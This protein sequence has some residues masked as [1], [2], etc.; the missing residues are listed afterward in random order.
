M[1]RCYPASLAARCNSLYRQTGDHYSIVYD[2]HRYIIVPTHEVE[3]YGF[4]PE[5]DE[6]Y[7]TYDLIA[8]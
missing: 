3:K 8:V 4:I 7:S 1:S 6:V 2:D 5:H